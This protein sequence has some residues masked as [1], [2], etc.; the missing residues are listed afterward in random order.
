MVNRLRPKVEEAVKRISKA[1]NPRKPVQSADG[2]QRFEPDPA[3][4]AEGETRWAIR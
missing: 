1:A 4:M 3:A 2:V